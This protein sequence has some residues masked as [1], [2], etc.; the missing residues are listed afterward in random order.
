MNPRPERPVTIPQVT[1]HA[2]N[3]CYWAAAGS[4]AAEVLAGLPALRKAHDPAALGLPTTTDTAQLLAAAAELALAAGWVQRVDGY[5]L[6][7]DH[8]GVYLDTEPRRF[9][10]RECLH[11]HR[12]RHTG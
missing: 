1:C 12:L 7:P 5:W 8:A 6:C 2:D 11:R 4:Q 10:I 3:G 9:T